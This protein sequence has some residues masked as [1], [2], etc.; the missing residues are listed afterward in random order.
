MVD[1]GYRV[2]GELQGVPKK[3]QGCYLSFFLRNILL[4]RK[5]CTSFSEVCQ[6]ALNIFLKQ[7][8]V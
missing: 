7:L 4:K 8:F 6:N 1:I 2:W 5:I 3:N